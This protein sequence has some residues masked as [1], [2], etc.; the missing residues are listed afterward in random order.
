V[1]A[2]SAT[3]SSSLVQLARSVRDDVVAPAVHDRWRSSVLGAAEAVPE[4]YRPIGGAG[5]RAEYL[6]MA[7]S[8]GW[9]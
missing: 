9:G 1:A 5:A 3:T 2:T 7:A 4:L 6:R 8:S